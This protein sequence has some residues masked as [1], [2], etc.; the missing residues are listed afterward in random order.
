MVSP[1]EPLVKTHDGSLG[2]KE[3][4]SAEHIDNVKAHPDDLHETKDPS[5]NRSREMWCDDTHN[6]TMLT[7][8]YRDDSDTK[9]DGSLVCSPGL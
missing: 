2:G 7:G 8:F 6:K 9:T 1:S 3:K 4:T 5:P